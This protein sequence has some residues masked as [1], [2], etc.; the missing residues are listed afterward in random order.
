MPEA[1][2]WVSALYLY[3][4]LFW[5]VGGLA[6]A[7]ALNLTGWRCRRRFSRVSVSLWLPFWLWVMWVLAGGVLSGVL[8]MVSGESFDWNA[9][10]EAPIILALV[11]FAVVLPFLILS[12]TN[13]FFRE[14]LK[15]LL[16]LPPAS[17]ALSAPP[18]APTTAT[19]AAKA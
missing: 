5:V 18:P 13:A 14:R 9:L 12:F 19:E 2:R 17:P 1:S 10:L 4:L 16:R 3:L 8:K 6:F 11:S 7:G 15:N